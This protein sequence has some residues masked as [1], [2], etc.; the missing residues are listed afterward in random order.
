MRPLS[1]R[2]P[3]T[4]PSSENPSLRDPTGR[5]LKFLKFWF[6]VFL[7]SGI[8]FWASSLPNLKPPVDLINIDK[9]C[10]LFEYTVFGFLLA[11]AFYA[12]CP[13]WSAGKTWRLAALCALLYGM[14]DEYHQSFVPGR[15]SSVLDAMADTMGGFLGAYLYSVFLN[16]TRARQ[17]VGP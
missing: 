12:Q 9:V 2:A 5:G 10:H 3:S 15:E 8:I 6:P 13:A 11:R 1:S 14:S 7:Y 16:K 17:K 4:R